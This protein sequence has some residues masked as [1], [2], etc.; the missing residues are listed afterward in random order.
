MRAD[1]NIKTTVSFLITRVKSPDV[2]NWGKLRHCLL[3]LKGTHYLKRYLLLLAESL[4]HIYWYIGASY[5]VH[6]VYKGYTGAIMTIGRW[7]LINVSR[8]YKLNVGS[9]T[10]LELVIIADVL[11]I[12]MWSKYVM[13]AQ[14]YMIKNNMLYQDNN[15]TIL[16]AKNR[17]MSA[18][19][20]SKHIKNRCF[21]ITDEIAQ[22][23]LSSQSKECVG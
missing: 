20:A 11:G 8:K 19:K 16:L 23:D 6:W 10:E 14:C 18:V 22:E 7:A 3:Y 13:E 12:M 15:S 9:S 21:L 17:I 4:S 1:P 2:D 5:G